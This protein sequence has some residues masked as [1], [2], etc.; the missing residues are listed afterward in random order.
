MVYI[1]RSGAIVVIPATERRAYF[2]GVDKKLL[3]YFI[4]VN[5]LMHMVAESALY[6]HDEMRLRLMVIQSRT[7]G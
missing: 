6:E 5:H 7:N 3:E 1:D 2:D 4:Q